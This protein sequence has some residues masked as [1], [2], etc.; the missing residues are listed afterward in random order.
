MAVPVA[1]PLHELAHL[2]AYYAVGVPEA[3]LHFNTVDG[4]SPNHPGWAL[5]VGAAGGPLMTLAIVGACVLGVRRVGPNPALVGMGL[6]APFRTLVPAFWLVIHTL[7]GR[8]NDANFDELNV[9]RALRWPP[10]PLML[11]EIA[12]V[13]TAIWWL[14][15]AMPRQNLRLNVASLGL[16]GALGIGLYWAVGPLLLP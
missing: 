13:A 6:V 12:I 1:G 2:L 16:G 7:W 10:Q 4:A 5:A 14:V 9:A 8:A 11:L 15:Q 3:V